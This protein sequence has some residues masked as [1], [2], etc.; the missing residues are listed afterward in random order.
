LNPVQ[1]F[2]ASF[3]AGASRE[4]LYDA[5]KSGNYIGMNCAAAVMNS[6]LTALVA[7][8]F[9]AALGKPFGRRLD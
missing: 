2:V 8:V 3:G 5:Q 6:R 4:I 1:A 7:P 9:R